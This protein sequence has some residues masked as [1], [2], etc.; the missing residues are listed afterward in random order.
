MVIYEPTN[1]AYDIDIGPVMLSDWYRNDY[2]TNIRG[3]MRLV[4]QGGPIDPLTNSN[5][6]NGKMRFP[7]EK[8]ILSCTTADYSVFKFTSGKNHLLRLINTGS[9]AVQK[10]AIDGHTMQVIANDFMPVVP[11]NTSMIALGVGQRADV[12][13]YGSAKSGDNV[14]MRSNIVGCSVNDGL[15]TEALGAIYY[16]D[17][18]MKTLPAAAPNQ[19]PAAETSPRFCGNDPL[20]VTVPAF[21]LKAST[22]GTT[23]DLDIRMKN[24]GT[25]ML[26]NFGDTSFRANLND[27]ILQQAL[28]GINSNYER[29]RSVENVGPAKTMRAIIS[30][31][32]NAPHPANHSIDSFTRPQHADPNNSGFGKADVN[33][34]VRP[35]NPQRRDV[36]I[37]PPG[38]EDRPSYLVIQWDADNPGVRPL[39][40]HFSWRSSLG[41]AINVLETPSVTS[42]V[43]G[44]TA[45][46]PMAQTCRA[47]NSFTKT[48]KSLLTGIDSGM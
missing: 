42:K 13:V 38:T 7:Y 46:G 16:Q 48:Q 12:I 37:M 1:K 41:L 33:A 35:E 27:P 9:N 30:N 21:P 44:P 23:K 6:I 8:T 10:F 24:N 28:V 14:W 3:L 47:W 5:L 20:T 34:I 15:L 2:M 43:M 22:P 29:N 19:G 4:S 31:Y 36:M 32:D 25:H 18:D 17:A 40:C 39:H 45:S 11:Y 26:L